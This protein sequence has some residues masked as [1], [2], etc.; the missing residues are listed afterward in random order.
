MGNNKRTLKKRIYMMVSTLNFA[1]LLMMSV[2]MTLALGVAFS[3]FSNLISENVGQQM[4][5]K[6]RNEWNNAIIEKRIPKKFNGLT[7]EY[8]KIFS[9]LGG[10]FKFF[11]STPI[12]I[13][14][15][16]QSGKIN[17]D[18]GISTVNNK[19]N[20]TNIKEVTTGN[21]V[22]IISDITK[23]FMP[24]LLAVEYKI[25]KNNTL[26]FDS[27]TPPDLDK[28]KNSKGLMLVRKDPPK[29]NWIMH[30]LNTTSNVDIKNDDGTE[31]AK[32]E[33]RLN[34]NV[35]ILGYIVLLS[36]CIIIFLIT[37]FFSKIATRMLSGAVVKP[38][39][40]LDC[41]MNQLAKGNLDAAMSNELILKKPVKEVESLANSSNM[42]M[43]R[44][45]DYIGT[46]ANQKLELEAQNL[47]LVENSRSLEMINMTLANKNSKLKNILDNVEQGF[48]TFKKNLLIHSEY[49]LICEKL[50][51]G[52]IS[53]R[54][55]SAIL[56]PNNS[57]MQ[58]FMDELL[59]KIFEAV[60]SQRKIY[61]PL[62]PEELSINDCVI[63][64]SYKVVMDEMNEE[65]IMVI[66][67]DITEKRLLEKRMDEERK[68]LKMVV[69]S[70]INRVEFLDLVKEFE[71]FASQNHDELTENEYDHTLRQIHTFKGNF[72]QY[73]MVN[74]VPKLNVLE[75]K[76]YEKGTDF[77]ITDIDNEE[78]LEWLRSDLDTIISYAGSDF[79]KDG[80]Y[81]YIKKDKLI[82][83]EKKI[84]QT[85]TKQECKV[86]LPL[87]KNLR[88]KSVKELL[89][90]YPEYTMKLSE[91]LEKAINPIEITG[92]EILVDTN[93]YSKMT[94]SLS[95]IF[96]NCIDHGI[97]TEDER[98]ELGK[99]Q[100]G[101]I[102]CDVKDAEGSFIITISDDGRGIDI[103]ALKEKVVSDG[104][105]TEEEW[106]KMTIK[107]KYDLI[108]E[109]GITT[110]EEATFISGRGVG[111]SAVKE[112]VMELGGTLIVDSAESKGTKFTVT[113]PKLE[114]YESALIT[115]EKFMEALID[116]STDIIYRNTGYK[117]NADKF[118]YKNTIIL[119]NI[120]ALISLSGTINSII[121]ISVNKNMA[122]SL[123]KGFIIENIEEEEIFNYAEDV[124][125]ELSNTIVGNAFGKFE[126][127]KGIFHI[128]LPAVLSNNEAYVKYTQS[129]II[130]SN[131]VC[132]DFEFSINMLLVEDEVDINVLKEGF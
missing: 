12:D 30:L 75:D 106:N 39:V 92:D 57:N 45:H 121:M 101:N 59:I 2:A 126:N 28:I 130:T 1:S 110:K 80:E 4:S 47:D 64:I 35:I 129:Q 125:S 7:P 85:L 107:Q 95:H 77:S 14:T 58:K 34:P 37:L 98:L 36:I 69:K 61:I 60:P 111:M 109:Q 67:T 52:Y 105:Y 89:K 27:S 81:C 96:R 63:N 104:L 76:L 26:L 5:M 91:R 43:S 24:D 18:K 99:E 20:D 132:D 103:N 112:C 22:T 90:T 128:G 53:G 32:L 23:N 25:W 113:I 19:F 16:E 13:G 119:N 65:T 122:K 71:E 68:T 49:S 41:K 51:N 86:I 108:F 46:L 62:L 120:T 72:S 56:F 123:A 97:E 116:T 54:T 15:D 8:I 40:D 17:N 87:I 93:Y 74:L 117:L 3:V 118:D 78:L 114:D 131:L 94:K 100:M 127:S 31:L 42:I 6:L 21:K 44:M 73:D 66:I 124:L 88:Y 33:V 29:D 55:L 50:F 38:L 70:I 115:S 84:Q 48:F 10:S 82:E 79:M 11:H 83:I 102:T 9:N